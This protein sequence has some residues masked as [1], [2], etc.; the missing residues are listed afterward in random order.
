MSSKVDYQSVQIVNISSADTDGN[1]YVDDVYVIPLNI[2]VADVAALLASY[3]E[4]DA[5]SPDVSTSRTIARLILSA[6]KAKVDEG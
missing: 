5:S 2:P 3:D 6:L 4:S 1:S